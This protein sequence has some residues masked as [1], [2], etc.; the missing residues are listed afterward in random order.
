MLLGNLAVMGEYSK[1]FPSD[2]HPQSLFTEMAKD[3]DLR[4]IYYLDLYPFAQPMVFLL[5]PAV[6]AQ[7]DRL[8]RHKIALDLIRGLAGTKSIFSTTG[9]EWLA[10]HSW[11]MPAFSISHIMTLVPG[12]VEETLVFREK[13]TKYA[14]SGETFLMNEDV[15]RLTIDVIARSSFDLRLESQTKDTPIFKHFQGA[16]GWAAGLTEP[17]FKKILSPYMMDYHTHK[18]DILLT[19]YIKKRSTSKTEDNGTKTILDLALKG[20]QKEM[21]KIGTP[22]SMMDPGFMKIAVDK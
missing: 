16:I 14:V 12:I 9:T 15:M 10:Q 13:L 22:T 2:C 21:G 20:Y 8:P 4:G 19:D 18:L 5:D 6:S 7:V 3:H 11:F 17:I 1:R